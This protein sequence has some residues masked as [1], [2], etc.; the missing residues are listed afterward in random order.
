M[1]DQTLGWYPKIDELFQLNRD[2]LQVIDRVANPLNDEVLLQPA[3]EER[4]AHL[5][6]PPDAYRYITFWR[7]TAPLAFPSDW[8]G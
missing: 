2:R 1:T 3:T 6:D 8:P 7:A 5:G 4:L